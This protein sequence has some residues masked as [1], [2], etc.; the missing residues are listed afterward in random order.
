MN[1]S[2]DAHIKKPVI[3]DMDPG[4][5]DAL[6]II[7][8]VKSGLL[9]IK[10]ITICGGNVS[11][12]QCALNALKTLR[13]A[14]ASPEPPVA[15]GASRPLKR[16]PFRASG[17][18]GPDGLGNVKAAYPDPQ[19]SEL[20][21]HSATEIILDTIRRQPEDA[22]LSIIVTGPLTNIA[23][24]ISEDSD[25]MRKVER[26]WWM[27]GS[28][29]KPGNISPVAEFNAY[30][31]PEAAHEV[32]TFGIPMT[33]VGLD[34]CMQ[35]P[36]SRQDIEN[37]LNSYATP[38]AKF[39]H[40]ITGMYMD[41]YRKQEGFHGCYLHDPLAVGVAIWSDLVTNSEKHHVEIITAPGITQG[42]TIIDRRPRNPWLNETCNESHDQISSHCQEHASVLREFGLLKT[43]PHIDVVLDVDSK[44][45]LEQFLTVCFS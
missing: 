17:I 32:M 24:A 23:H 34:A 15:R 29:T 27:G 28:Y 5:D 41:F 6:A 38:T 45:F 14:G 21:H 40:E 44:K 26:I 11:R 4:V 37:A 42:M 9:D 31:D 2:R 19:I 8:A 33:V 39:A 12:D 18:H 7:L 10:A 35:C 25:T 22:P 3:L 20:S 13:V 30:C 43:P 36:L 16:T 1:K